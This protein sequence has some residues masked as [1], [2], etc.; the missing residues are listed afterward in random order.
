[1]R[2]A[3]QEDMLDGATIDERFTAA[4][5][6]GVDGI[7]LWSAG[8][9]ERVDKARG[10]AR[11]M[12]VRVAVVNATLRQS[13]VAADADEQR[14][15]AAEVRRL[16]GLCARVGAMGLVYHPALG[17]PRL[18]RPLPIEQ[19]RAEAAQLL[20]ERLRELAHAAS[21]QGV[22]LLLEPV[23]RFESYTLNTLREAAALCREVGGEGLGVCANLYHMRLEGEDPA[24]ASSAAGASLR[25]IHVSDVGRRLPTNE[26]SP[27]GGELHALRRAGYDGYL[28]LEA[29]TPGQN[30]S[31][32]RFF[33]RELPGAVGRVRAMMRAM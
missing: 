18:A 26:T 11:L 14:Y 32:R 9:A 17:G 25:Y 8:L 7:E 4:E 12:G 24:A 15:A 3:V 1:M 30:A 29:L 6:A 5:S 23:N 16:L 21:E 27:L 22:R 28:G 33:A 10:L 20:P 19:A 31:L 2:L 13:L